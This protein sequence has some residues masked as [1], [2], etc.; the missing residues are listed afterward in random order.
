MGKA[1]FEKIGDDVTWHLYMFHHFFTHIDYCHW[2]SPIANTLLHLVTKFL[3]L[4]HG[5][6]REQ[7]WSNTQGLARLGVFVE[8]WEEVRD[9][10]DE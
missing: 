6:R 5:S 1:V 9:D 7:V 3:Q 4:H 8:P 10:I 2:P